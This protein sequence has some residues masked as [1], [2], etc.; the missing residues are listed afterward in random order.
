MDFLKNHYEKIILSVVLLGLAVVA[1]YLPIEVSNVRTSLADF[2][3]R[4]MQGPVEPID[5]LDLSTNQAVLDR[6]KAYNGAPFS[7]TGHNVFNPVRW[8]RGPDGTPIPEADLGIR[9]LQVVKI[10]P[11]YT[12]ITFDDVRDSGQTIRYQVKEVQETSSKGSEQRGVVR[13]MTPGDQG[14]L[15]RLV[16]VQ[17]PPEAPTGLVFEFLGSKQRV[18]VTREKPFEQVAGYSADLRHAATNRSYNRQRKDDKL[19]IGGEAYKIVAIESDAVTLENVHTL[20]RTTI[21]P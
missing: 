10:T 17:G 7:R 13:Y 14:E 3:G 15:F 11:L 6:L 5:P 18:V 4:V 1:A 2:T 8:V 21:R 19:A 16:E 12:R 20:K 9:Q